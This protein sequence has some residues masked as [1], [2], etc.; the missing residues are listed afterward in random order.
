[1]PIYF[2]IRKSPTESTMVMFDSGGLERA[3]RYKQSLISDGSYREDQV[4]IAGTDA[5]GEAVDA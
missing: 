5:D 3:K 2:T 1:M 4:T